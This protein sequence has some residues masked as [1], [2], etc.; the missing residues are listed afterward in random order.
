MKVVSN[1]NQ[2]CI[3]ALFTVGAIL[4]GTLTLHAALAQG[5]KAVEKFPGIVQH[6]IT[7]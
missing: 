2:T 5:E 6:D 7:L 1:L 3:L 4:S